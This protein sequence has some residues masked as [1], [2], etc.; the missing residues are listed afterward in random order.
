MQNALL[1]SALSPGGRDLKGASANR[2]LMAIWNIL[3]M[4]V[5][6]NLDFFGCFLD[7]TF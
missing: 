3:C 1:A 7:D 2:G 4:S 6:H 5:L